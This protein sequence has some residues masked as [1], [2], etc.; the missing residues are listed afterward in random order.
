MVMQKV[1]LL[2]MALFFYHG[3]ETSVKRIELPVM[4]EENRTTIVLMEKRVSYR[5]DMKASVV[6][7]LPGELIPADGGIWLNL[8]AYNDDSTYLRAVW[9][10]VDGVGGYLGTQRLSGSQVRGDGTIAPGDILSLRLPLS[11]CPV[12]GK[13]SETDLIDFASMLMAPGP[14]IVCA[15]V[16]T[17]EEYGPDS[18]ISMAI[19]IEGGE[20]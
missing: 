9:F 19:E 1:A 7:E 13:E 2:I 12:A 8:E 5:N 17:Y 16:S 4:E 15:W 6:F 3:N 10:S 20:Q 14:H 18:W 11:R